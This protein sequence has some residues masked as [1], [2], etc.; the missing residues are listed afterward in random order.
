[1]H[2]ILHHAALMIPCICLMMI[3]TAFFKPAGDPRDRFW[4][5]GLGSFCAFLQGVHKS[6]PHNIQHPP[7][8][9]CSRR[10]TPLGD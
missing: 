9:M 4:E 7:G 8:T 10:F 5:D 2:D 6:L 1:M 3:E